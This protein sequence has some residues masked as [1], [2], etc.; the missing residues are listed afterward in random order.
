ML[1]KAVIVV[2]HR[3]FRARHHAELALLPMAGNHQH[4]LGHH[5]DLARDVLERVFEDMERLAAVFHVGPGP[6]AVGDEIGGESHLPHMQA[7]WP[8]FKA[9]SRGAPARVPAPGQGPATRPPAARSR[10][11]SSSTPAPPRAAPRKASRCRIRAAEHHDVDHVLGLV[12]LLAPE[13]GEQHFAR[14]IGEREVGGPL[15]RLE[16]R[17]RQ[18]GQA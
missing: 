3:R 10:A 11:R 7:V 18:K 5:A 17:S 4:G 1:G 8:D 14:G 13:H 6:A 2:D 12:L 15:Q 16:R 9:A